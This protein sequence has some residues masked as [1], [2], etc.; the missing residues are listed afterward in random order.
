MESS[1]GY[2]LEEQ[3]VKGGVFEI[4]QP[5]ERI[6]YCTTV[7]VA[8]SKFLILD[9]VMEAEPSRSDEE[10]SQ[11][12]P[13]CHNPEAEK[14]TIHEDNLAK[15]SEMSE[16]EILAERQQLLQTIGKLT[17]CCYQS[18]VQCRQ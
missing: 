13:S 5:N 7:P 11:Y 17:Q 8:C 15:L 10:H 14:K 18:A 4:V 3:A 2:R 16:E 12:E 9:I 1:R 6:L